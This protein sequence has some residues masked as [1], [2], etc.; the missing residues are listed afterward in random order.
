MDAR[1]MLPRA[2]IHA[3][4]PRMVR[5]TCKLQSVASITTSSMTRHCASISCV[6]RLN[7]N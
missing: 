3:E 5:W 6:S 7:V 2:S 1:L 4:Q